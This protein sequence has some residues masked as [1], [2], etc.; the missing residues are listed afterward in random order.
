MFSLLL[1]RILGNPFAKRFIPEMVP[2]TVEQ[3][4]QVDAQYEALR[5]YLQQQ[6]GVSLRFP[7]AVEEAMLGEAST[8]AH[9][10]DERPG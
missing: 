5:E 6:P 1:D 4:E 3:A 8:G 2:E 7:V 9:F 10:S